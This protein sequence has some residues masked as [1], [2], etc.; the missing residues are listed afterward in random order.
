MPPR[1]S[2]LLIGEKP[3][4]AVYLASPSFPVEIDVVFFPARRIGEDA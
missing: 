2:T 1:L 4:D 3:I